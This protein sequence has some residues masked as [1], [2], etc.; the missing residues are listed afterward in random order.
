LIN[1]L[2]IGFFWIL[3]AALAGGAFGLQ[4]RIMRHYQVENASLLSMFVAT[5]PIP[6]IACWLL[7]P[8]WTDAI[9]KAGFASNAIIFFFGFCWGLG[10]ITY[11]YGFNLLGMALAAS[12]LKG[13]SIAIGAGIPLV[14]HWNQVSV[15]ARATT[16]AGL[17]ILMFGTAVAGKAGIMRE[18]EAGKDS[19][20]PLSPSGVNP[21]PTGRLFWIGLALCLI[22]GFA[23]SGANLGYDRADVIERSMVEVSNMTNLTWKA[24]LVRWM[25]MY[26]GGITAL[27]IFMGGAMLIRGTWR[28]YLAKGSLQD[29]LVSSSMGAVH[30]MAQIPYGIGAFYLGKLGTTVGWGA[31]IGMALI[32]ASGLGFLTGEWKGASKTATHML[33]YAIVILIGAIVVLASANSLA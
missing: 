12:L 27:L 19:A 22:S 24:T 20:S 1:P 18:K 26:W 17:A 10:A 21:K 7:L 15:S 33:Y 31:N 8:G 25:P 28:C 6:L 9:S 29:L 30:F 13:I 32:V 4:Y 5:V 3:I 2:V 11:A 23:S 16:I 14:R